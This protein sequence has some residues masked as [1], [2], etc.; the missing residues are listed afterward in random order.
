MISFRFHVVSITAVFLAIAIGVVVGTTY[1]DGAVVDGLR[2]RIDSVESNLDERKA[3]ND[4]LERELDLA[5][6]YIDD[7]A[8]FAVTNRLT[9]VPV[10]VVATRGID[11]AAVE[12]TGA[13]ARRAGATTPGVVWLE[14]TW[15]LEGEDERAALASILDVDAE[16]DPDEMRADAW[17]AVV[18]ELSVPADGSPQGVDAPTAVLEPLVE[19]G[20]LTVDSLDDPSTEVTDL[21]GTSPRVLTVTGTRAE[22]GPEALVGV[23]AESAVDNELVSVFADVHVDAPEATGRGEALLASMPADA[24]ELMAVVDNADRIEGQVA[25]V[26]ALDA[27]ADGPVGHL[28]YGDGA[29]GVVPAWTPP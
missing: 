5:N 26:L 3:E 11:E 4:R 15:S 17:A 1:V 23:I 18:A 14:P 7:S 6:T 20:F 24:L 8:D 16:A 21:A 27:A 9:D 28:G 2:N 13:L 22:S 29:V 10:L 12:R 19:A 25:S